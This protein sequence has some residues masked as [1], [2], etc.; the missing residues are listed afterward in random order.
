LKVF[1]RAVFLINNIATISRLV[2]FPLF[3]SLSLGSGDHVHVSSPQLTDDPIQIIAA[4]LPLRLPKGPPLTLSWQNGD[5]SLIKL[6]DDDPLLVLSGPCDRL[7]AGGGRHLQFE[8]MALLVRQLQHLLREL[9]KSSNIEAIRPRRG[10][11]TETIQERDHLVTIRSQ[12]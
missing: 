8:F 6:I 10:A 12:F 4:A 7:V 2:S 5:Q 11:I 1:E 3:P 9:R